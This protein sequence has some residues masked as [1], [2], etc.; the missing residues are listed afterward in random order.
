MSEE[1]SQEENDYFAL[2]DSAIEKVIA[3]LQKAPYNLSEDEAK[4]FRSPMQQSGTAVINGEGFHI[5]RSANEFFRV[6]PDAE[7]HA[8]AEQQHA[9]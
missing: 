1:F 8:D 6:V 9:A 3:D 7:S 4:A 5:T 2:E